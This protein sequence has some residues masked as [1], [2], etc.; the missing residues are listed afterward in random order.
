MGYN[1]VKRVRSDY[2][3]SLNGKYNEIEKRNVIRS[4]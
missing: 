1:S 3:R 4:K 2:E